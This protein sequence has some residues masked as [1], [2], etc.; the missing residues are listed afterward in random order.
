MPLRESDEEQVDNSK[1]SK[2]RV[3]ELN[4]RGWEVDTTYKNS[5]IRNINF[6]TN[7]DLKIVKRDLLL[8]K[9]IDKIETV[10]EFIEIK[11]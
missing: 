8:T 7:N 3:A 6:E 2:E 10:N 1:L 9:F 4:L 5:P 11:D